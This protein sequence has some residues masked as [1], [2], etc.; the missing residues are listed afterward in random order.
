LEW[1]WNWFH[2]K[3]R[4]NQVISWNK[5]AYERGKRTKDELDWE[6]EQRWPPQLRR[7]IS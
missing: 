3:W 1:V 2:M 6:D 7:L 5:I 4:D